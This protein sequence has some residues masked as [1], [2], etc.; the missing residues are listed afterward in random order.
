MY[1]AIHMNILNPEPLLQRKNYLGRYSISLS[2]ETIYITLVAAVGNGLSVFLTVIFILRTVD[3]LN[4]A[5]EDTNIQTGK[6]VLL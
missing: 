1:H 5:R 4:Y 3:L 2:L 6:S